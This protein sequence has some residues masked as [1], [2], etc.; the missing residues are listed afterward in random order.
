MEFAG[1]FYGDLHQEYAA[2]GPPARFSVLLERFGVYGGFGGAADGWGPLSH[3][4][5]VWAALRYHRGDAEDAENGY[6]KLE[7]SLSGISFL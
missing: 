2:R 5:G 7:K 4:G 1:L 6:L 3:K